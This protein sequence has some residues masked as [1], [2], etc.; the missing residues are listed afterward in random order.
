MVFVSAYDKDYVNNA[1]KAY[2]RHDVKCPYTD[3][4]FDLEI[5]L[6]KHAFHL[7]MDYLLELM[8]KACEANRISLSQEEV[9]EKIL[10]VEDYLRKRL[11]TV[12]DVKRFTNQFLYSYPT[13]QT[14]VYFEDYILVELMKFSHKEEYDKLRDTE[15]VNVYK[16]GKTDIKVCYLTPSLYQRENRVEV[17]CL[18]LLE[19]L[20]PIGEADKFDSSPGRICNANSFDIYFYNNE[21]DH[22]FQKDFDSLYTLSLQ[23]CCDKIDLW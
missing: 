9:R 18:D 7:L 21:Y 20:F 12:R 16:K 6:P 4:Y 8:K 14:E 23:E 17:S 19:K 11:H 1:L 10:G 13:I 15:Y 22:I 5:K 3:K 2:L